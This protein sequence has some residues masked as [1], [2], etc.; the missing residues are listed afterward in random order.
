MD[1]T[2]NR[3]MAKNCIVGIFDSDPNVQILN[4]GIMYKL[5]ILKSVCMINEKDKV[6]WEKKFKNK[7]LLFWIFMMLIFNYIPCK[8]FFCDLDSQCNI[9]IKICPPGKTILHILD[10]KSKIGAIV[11][12]NL[13]YLMW[14]RHLIRSRAV[15]N[16]IFLLQKRHI[17]LYTGELC[18][19]LPYHVSTMEKHV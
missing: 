18:F 15:T 11:L 1:S 12:S 6:V 3:L 19:E 9:K 8:S 10:G 17:L 14:W 4:S 16:I 13:C 2:N 5:Q 7:M